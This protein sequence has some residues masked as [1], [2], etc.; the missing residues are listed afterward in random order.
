[1][2]IAAGS[3]ISV[4]GTQLATTTATATNL[5]LP[6]AL[7]GVRVLV[8]DV[9][10]P[11]LFVAPGQ[12]NAQVPYEVANTSLGL[13]KVVVYGQTSA[14]VPVQIAQAAPGIFTLNQS[15]SGRGAVLHGVS[16]VPLTDANPARP[17]EVLSVF[18]SG[19]GTT[20]PAATNGVA[21]TGSPLQTTTRPVTASI[22]GLSAPVS[23]SGLA[24]GFA[25][26]YQVNVQVPD[27]LPD[28]EQ[29]LTISSADVSSNPVTIPVHR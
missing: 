18:A 9:E 10:A 17:G 8:N 29:P 27:T 3:L 6:T 11:L 22:G 21:A 5:P 2:R 25:G 13:L 20:N 26:L 16:G 7:S 24:P 28:G 12:I 14:T 23:F 4:F 1:L 19:L 15:G